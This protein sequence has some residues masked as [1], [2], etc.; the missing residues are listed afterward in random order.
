MRVYKVG[1][2]TT[3]IG[4]INITSNWEKDTKN[5]MIQTNRVR[6][7]FPPILLSACLNVLAH[8][9]LKE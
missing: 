9:K 4:N 2:M 6:T 1:Q 8:K 3:F 7:Y 5:H